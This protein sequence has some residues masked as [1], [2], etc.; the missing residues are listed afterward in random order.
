MCEDRAPWWTV[1][2]HSL[3]DTAPSLR[4]LALR[5]SQNRGR[6]ETTITPN[7]AERVAKWGHSWREGELVWPLWEGLGDFL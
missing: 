3:L 2:G 1:A 4:D 6:L 7:A 5:L